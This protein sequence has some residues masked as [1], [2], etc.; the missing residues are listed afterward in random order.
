MQF[1]NI[2]IHGKKSQLFVTTQHDKKNNTHEVEKILIDHTP[3]M[4]GVLKDSQHIIKFVKA[5][6]WHE[7]VK[8]LW[9]HSRIT[10]EIKGSE[11]LA[12]L[13]LTVP[14]IYEAG[15]GIIPSKQY[16]YI[17][18][19]VMENLALSGFQELSDLIREGAIDTAMREKIMTAVFDGLKLMRDNR[20]V[21]S[22]FHLDNVFA[23]SSGDITWIDSGVTTY[24]K[25]NEKKFIK[26]F[27][28]SI[29]RYIN[30]QYTGVSLLSEDESTKLKQ[31]FLL[32]A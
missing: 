16:E 6:S 10:K 1:S 24:T 18:Y 32:A 14:T 25:M 17:G 19:Y 12:G 5:R 31:L 20:I 27:N 22:D 9:N 13:G 8:L 11:L 7:Y 30:Y 15:L 28:Q 3:S 21:F 26:K 2:K 4:V 29:N 23:N